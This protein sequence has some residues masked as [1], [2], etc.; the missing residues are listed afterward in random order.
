[1]TAPRP[2]RPLPWSSPET[3][4]QPSLSSRS[5]SAWHDE[6]AMILGLGGLDHN[7]AAC[8]VDGGEVLAMLESYSWPGNVRELANA[9]ERALILCR[10]GPIEARH[11]GIL[12]DPGPAEE[13]GFATLREMEQRHILAA[14]R[15]TEGKVSGPGGA[16][17]L[18][19]GFEV[20]EGEKILLVEDVVTTGDSALRAIQVV[21]EA[22]GRV[23]GVLAVVD[24]ENSG[25]ERLERAGYPLLALFTASELLQD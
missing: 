3:T 6:R 13:R 12:A 5:A 10:E 4:R 24:R 22:G 17:E 21:E 20:A 11:V 25:R 14:L 8:L 1:M 7:G 9:I 2:T 23:L 18:R 15:Q 19:R 16:A